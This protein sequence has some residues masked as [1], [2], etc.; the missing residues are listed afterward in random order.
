MTRRERVVQAIFSAVDEVNEQLLKE[1]QLKK[2]IDT[3]LFGRSGKL[4]SLGLVTLIV[5]IEQ[6]IEEQFG[7]TITIADDK[8]MS[9]KDSPFKTIGTLVDYISWLLEENTNR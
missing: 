7:V 6:K 1:E 4:D 3:V 2:S 8:A 9:Q 5:A